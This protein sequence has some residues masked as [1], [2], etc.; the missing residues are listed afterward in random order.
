MVQDIETIMVV[1]DDRK[2]LDAIQRLLRNES[3]RSMTFTSPVKA[4]SQVNRINPA[5][6]LSDQYMHKMFGTVFIEQVKEKKPDS[7][8][9]IMTGHI[10]IDPV[11]ASIIQGD[12]F[13]FIKK[14]WSSHKF[15][16]LIR[17]T[18]NHYKRLS[19]KN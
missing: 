7:I 6:V 19:K 13:T 18:L 10:D 8:G 2:L 9:I 5:I 11:I 16:S 15:K 17:D 1:D 3:L 14:P 12:V 4:L